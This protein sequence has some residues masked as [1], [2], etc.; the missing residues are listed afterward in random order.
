M[1]ISRIK[2]L[3]SMPKESEFQRSRK[4]CSVYGVLWSGD[5]PGQDNL[6]IL[7]ISLS[8]RLRYQLTRWRMN[9]VGEGKKNCGDF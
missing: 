5:F 7:A 6:L 2:N 1:T 8:L 3:V 9:E 4:G